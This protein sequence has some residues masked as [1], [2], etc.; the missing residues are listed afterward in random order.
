MPTVWRKHRNYVWILPLCAVALFYQI[1]YS[2][3]AIRTVYNRPAVPHVPFDSADGTATYVEKSV[4]AAG[5]HVGDRLV[6]IDGKSFDN[7]RELLE[8]ITR[9]RPGEFLSV[10]EQPKGHAVVETVKIPITAFGDSGP[11][12]GIA[13]TVGMAALML[14]CVVIAVYVALRRPDDKRA[15]FAFSLIV[16]LAQVITIADWYRFPRPLWTFALAW[17]YACILNWSVA[18]AAFGLYFPER[19]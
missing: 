18:I 7:E 2:V 1:A 10:A 16:S 19:F 14:T 11:F 9:H 4:D 17:K 13:L 12:F 15:L 6:S 8:D 5:L 3:V